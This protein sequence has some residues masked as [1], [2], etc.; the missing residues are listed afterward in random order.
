MPA[1]TTHYVSLSKEEKQKQVIHKLWSNTR[2]KIG[3]PPMTSNGNQAGMSKGSKELNESTLSSSVDN[4]FLKRGEQHNGDENNINKL[5][6]GVKIVT[7][8][9]HEHPLEEVPTRMLSPFICTNCRQLLYDCA[10]QCKT[11][12]KS[13]NTK[14]KVTET[15]AAGNGL[16]AASCLITHSISSSSC[17]SIST[18]SASSS[19]QAS[20]VYFCEACYQAEVKV[21]MEGWQ[22]VAAAAAAADGHKEGRSGDKRPGRLRIGRTQANLWGGQAGEQLW[23]QAAQND[24]DGLSPLARACIDGSTSLLKEIF[25]CE[26]MISLNLDDCIARGKYKGKT[27][28]ML[29]AEAG[30]AGVVQLLMTRVNRKATDEKGMTALM[31]ASYNGHVEVVNELLYFGDVALE[32]VALCGYTA[33]LFA[34]N[35]GHHLLCRRLLLAGANPHAHTTR[36][37]NALHVAAFNGHYQ[38]VQVLIEIKDM[39]LTAID[40]E[41]YNA[42]DAALSNNFCAV[43]N[44]IKRKMIATNQPFLHKLR[45]L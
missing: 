44:V 16:S 15:A 43:A 11:C 41:G 33:L 23:W 14:R 31:L 24:P 37:R 30:H 34:A 39:D 17:S 5:P 42:Y 27:P 7:W 45:A 20:K 26:F 40:D 21:S 29:A 22:Q 10:H 18:S 2:I 13:D 35:R 36:R 38:T 9:L 19:S 4:S 3:D 1:F 32:H 6:A 28:L 12:N 25:R 8:G